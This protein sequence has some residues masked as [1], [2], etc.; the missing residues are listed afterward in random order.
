M[1]RLRQLALAVLSLL[2]LGGGFAAVASAEDGPPAILLLSGSVTELNGSFKGGTGE[3]Q[4]L[5]GKTLDGTGVTG[6]ISGCVELGRSKTD[7]NLCHETTVTITGVKQGKV[8]C[9]S[10][11]EKKKKDQEGTILVH[12]DAHL[13]DEKTSGGVLEPLG[14][15]EVLGINKESELTINCGGVK[16]KIKGR[17]GCLISPGLENIAAGGNVKLTCE[18]KEGDQIIGKCVETPT[19]CKELEE[20][21]FLANLGG[22]FEM[23][24]LRIA[25]EG[26]V[27][28]DIFIDD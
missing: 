6:T 26:S 10:E 14:I 27:N 1:S 15:A 9:E 22:G 21:P 12:G 25:L 5:G 13:A 17:L 20:K 28:K 24:G 18:Q 23:S 8:N 2:A 3:L 16:D 11:N 7:T 19:L 4:T